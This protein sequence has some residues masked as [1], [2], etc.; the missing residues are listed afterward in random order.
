MYYCKKTWSR[1]LLCKPVFTRHLIKECFES[2]VP[3]NFVSNAP[4][5]FVILW[6]FCLKANSQKICMTF[7]C[8]TIT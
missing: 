1:L 6:F 2:A 7:H 5:F 8:F 4:T 3:A